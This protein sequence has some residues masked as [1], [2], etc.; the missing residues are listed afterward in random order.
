MNP[1]LHWLNA[2]EWTQLVAALL[3]SLWQGALLAI[4][5]AVLLRRLAQPRLRYYASLGTLGI[6][7]LASIITWAVLTAPKTNAPVP[8][9][10]LA[11]ESAVAPTFAPTLNLDSPDKVI[12]FGTP[13]SPAPPT[14]PWTAWLAMVW[15]LGT[16]I[17]LLRAGIK[18]AGAE[19][20][21]RSCQPLTD[22]TMTLLVVEAC[23][24]I[25]LARKIRVAVTD[26]LTS[27]A[28][29]GILVPTL[30]LPL[31]LF[32]TL[33]PEQIRFILLHELAHIR[34]GDYLANLFQ[35]LAEALLF[36]NPA[37]W[38]LSHHIRRE[39]E[40][41]CDALA[42]E[43]SGAPADYA[44][45]LV[46]VAENTLP[47]GPTTALAF[48]EDG[49]E[50]SSLADRV[51][52]LLVP[53]YR[54]ALRLT[55]RAMLTS[56][57]VGGTLLFL[58]AVGTRN[59]VGAILSPEKPSLEGH[60]SSQSTL[61]TA[62]STSDVLPERFRT[63]VSEDNTNDSL[64][65]RIFQIPRKAMVMLSG[66]R[67]TNPPHAKTESSTHNS[68]PPETE[69]DIARALRKLI[70][71]CNLNPANYR[72]YSLSYD[73]QAGALR[74]RATRRDL[75]EM[76]MVIRV[77]N[78]N[79]T[80]EPSA[81]TTGSGSLWVDPANINA[82][83]TNAGYLIAPPAILTESAF[84]QLIE[85][86]ENRDGMHLTN[87]APV[88]ISTGRVAQ[89]GTSMIER[90][91]AAADN[92]PSRTT[93]SESKPPQHIEISGSGSMSFDY[94]SETISVTN[95]GRV[96]FLGQE[97]T[98]DHIQI[99]RATGDVVARGN[100]RFVTT[101]GT[102]SGSE[103]R[104]T[105][106]KSTMPTTNIPT[107]IEF[108]GYD[109]ATAATFVPAAITGTGE[110]NSSV[111]PLPI[112]RV[113]QNTTSKE[114]V[115]FLG[116]LPEFAE[117]FSGKSSQPT[118]QDLGPV[119]TTNNN[120]SFGLDDW[121]VRGGNLDRQDPTA[122]QWFWY[123]TGAGQPSTQVVSQLA[124][125]SFNVD[126]VAL[127]S[128]AGKSAGFSGPANRTNLGPAIRAFFLQSG[129]DLDPTAGK[130][131]YLNLTRGHIY[132]RATPAELD[133]I[134]ALL[135]T[136]REGEPLERRT[137]HIDSKEL[138]EVRARVP[139]ALSQI[140]STNPATGL[141]AILESFNS[142]DPRP[143]QVRAFPA[144]N[145]FT[146]RATAE[147]FSQFET[148]FGISALPPDRLL[149]REYKLP[150][151][152]VNQRILTNTAPARLTG[153]TA[154][155]QLGL[156]H[157]ALRDWFSNAAVDL[158]PNQG[159]G[160]L[161][162]DRAGIVLARATT[163]ELDKIESAIQ[164][165]MWQPPQVNLKIRWVETAEP[166]EVFRLNTNAH[167]IFVGAG[168]ISNL[169]GTLTRTQ[170]NPFFERLKTD[171]KFRLV[172]EGQVTTTTDRQAQIQVTDVKTVVTGIDPRALQPPGIHDDNS[173]NASYILSQAVPLGPVIDLLPS[174]EPDGWNI[175]IR[176]LATVTEF[177]GYASGPEVPIYVNGQESR[178]TLPL[179]K[180]LTRQL[181]NDFVLRDSETFYFGNRHTVES[182][183]QP[184]GT[185]RTNDI[186]AQQTN[187]L[188]V[189]ITAMIIDPTGI[190]ANR[191]LGL[192]SKLILPSRP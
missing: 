81:E 148:L 70:Y 117:Y 31:S 171:P 33:T 60:Q 128:A 146:A 187:Y 112:F 86:I 35:L 150:V 121:T 11:T 73:A 55:W 149:T 22:E 83:I 88:N 127:S 79:S 165:L 23:R 92:L 93:N 12:A 135:Q 68:T 91:V 164:E 62:A 9:A 61:S 131:Y 113:R 90:N 82:S 59:T 27:P 32:T 52:R 182:V 48:G 110:S 102:Y 154:S 137:Y 63:P 39:R 1:L 65:I 56:L 50:P 36:F 87:S 6:L 157:Q 77:L 41:C 104:M 151:E 44:K 115:P 168:K 34:R 145:E 163:E 42:I 15:M 123:R 140:L 38:W 141:Q 29:V 37:V 147:D 101:N 25:N 53:G 57:C 76:E 51:Q 172:N 143:K 191:D 72:S 111:L 24:A 71:L 64:E 153:N 132:V 176:A 119:N 126:P 183:K 162:N 120:Q 5:L 107:S 179:P 84:N 14:V 125:R 78:L 133:T 136:M 45:T 19:K 122:R 28:V 118:K 21:R 85:S 96:K 134:E 58:S 156:V 116:D 40:A 114:K 75:D 109:L 184:D 144:R 13:I 185:F 161:F 181:T 130:S 46:R 169:S 2:P 66:I 174:V 43:L 80:P 95:G 188:V 100:A 17:M 190:P 47:T 4:L 180:Y 89:I 94:N 166:L 129:V 175:K 49:R 74:V 108:V 159:K 160:I 186:T 8:P 54:P 98:A 177:A 178:T 139:T 192:P 69:L 138:A 106:P 124:E 30:I 7:V 10:T 16:F 105:I 189:F 99:D 67:S 20:L 103:L 155:N 152:F 26:Q 18:V 173:T 158:N 97:I 170:A 142:E 3:H 167:N